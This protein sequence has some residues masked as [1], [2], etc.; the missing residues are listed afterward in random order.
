MWQPD[1]SRST[2]RAT[3][4]AVVISSRR[5]HGRQDLERIEAAIT[6]SWIAA[7]PVVGMTV[8]DLE[9]WIGQVEPGGDIATYLRAWEVD[10]EVVAFSWFDPPNSMDWHIR[11]DRWSDHA[12]AAVAPFPGGRGARVAPAAR[13]DRGAADRDRHVCDG[14]GQA[15]RRG[16]PEARL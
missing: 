11:L 7:R 8:G 15:D 3:L 12:I 10:D 6:A 9:W 16:P 13:H 5:Y 4:R 14:R 2:A 1:A